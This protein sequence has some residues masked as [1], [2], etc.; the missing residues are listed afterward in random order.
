MDLGN[1]YGRIGILRNNLKVENNIVQISL[2]QYE[3]LMEELEKL[4]VD[5]STIQKE[6]LRGE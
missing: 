3:L 2:D 1:H 4:A 6:I 5:I